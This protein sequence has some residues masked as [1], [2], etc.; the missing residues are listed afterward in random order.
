MLK[1]GG[2]GMFRIPISM[3]PHAVVEFQM[4]L[5]IIGMISLFY[6]AWVCLGQT[7]LKRMVAYSSVSHMGITSWNC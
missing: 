4:V 1:M 5:M 3:F 2:Y 7:N 6:G